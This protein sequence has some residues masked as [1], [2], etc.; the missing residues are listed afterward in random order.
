MMTDIT[1]KINTL[2]SNLDTD[3]R[4][5]LELSLALEPDYEEGEYGS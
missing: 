4:E 3:E 1:E 5:E 2:I